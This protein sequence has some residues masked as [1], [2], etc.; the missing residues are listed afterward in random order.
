MSG[1]VPFVHCMNLV[2]SVGFDVPVPTVTSTE[3]VNVAPPWPKLSG[4]VPVWST[5]ALSHRAWN[6]NVPFTFT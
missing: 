1:P 6:V 4:Y 5:T 2:V 3:S